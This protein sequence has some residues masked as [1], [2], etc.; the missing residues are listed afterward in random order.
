MTDRPIA[1]PRYC[2]L[3]A[4]AGKEGMATVGHQHDIRVLASVNGTSSMEVFHATI[5]GQLD[6]LP[7]YGRQQGGPSQVV[8]RKM[9]V[10]TRNAG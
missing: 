6:G 1:R 10:A 4:E 2:R 3:V 7:R 5:G 8:G 9:L